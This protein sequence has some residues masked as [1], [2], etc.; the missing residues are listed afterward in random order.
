MSGIPVPAL[1]PLGPK[2]D[3]FVREYLRDMSAP[4][5]AVR[6]GYQKTAGARLVK[7]PAIRDAIDNAIVQNTAVRSDVRAAT[8]LY[9]Y[10]SRPPNTA[11]KMYRFGS[12]SMSNLFRNIDSDADFRM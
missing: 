8:L 1:R 6:A 7:N 11:M 10:A 4:M 3:M 12:L 2:E 9:T 5:A